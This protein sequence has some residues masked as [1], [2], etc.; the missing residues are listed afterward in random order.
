MTTT[1]ATG[2]KYAVRR[3]GVGYP[4]G[5]AKGLFFPFEMSGPKKM[6]QSRGFRRAIENPLPGANGSAATVEKKTTRKKSPAKTGAVK[7]RKKTKAAS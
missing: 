3:N 2:S 7:R 6:T 4:V 5:G 1:D